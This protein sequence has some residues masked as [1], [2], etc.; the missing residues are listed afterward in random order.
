MRCLADHMLISHPSF[1]FTLEH[2]NIRMKELFCLKRACSFVHSKK[3]KKNYTT[4][5]EN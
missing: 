2:I 4:I 3:Y 5:K 1:P